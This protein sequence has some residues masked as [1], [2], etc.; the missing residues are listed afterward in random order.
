[1]TSPFPDPSSWKGDIIAVGGELSPEILLSAYTQGIFPWYGPDDPILWQSPDPRM[2]LFP[3][4]LHISR[5][6]RT[7]LK[8][9]VFTITMNRDFAAV[10]RGCAEIARP[11]QDGT[12]INDDIIAAYTELHRLGF[13][14]SA[15]A[16]LNGELAGG[17]YG[18]LL[19]NM[20]CGES[21]FARKPNASK[22]AFLTL[23][24]H[25]F[26]AGT[27]FI[28]CQIPTEHLYSLGGEVISRRT[29][30]KLLR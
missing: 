12:W 24:Q 3:E 25:L 7:I 29:F 11:G 16:W 26:A 8:K 10:I 6:M 9:G 17:C 14:L 2:V 23:A 4:N 30:L 20:F 21:M 18:I 1:L 15:E 19:D 5:S 13:V 22:A 28:D 27:A